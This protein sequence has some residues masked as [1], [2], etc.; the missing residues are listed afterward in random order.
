MLHATKINSHTSWGVYLAFLFSMLLKVI[1]KPQTNLVTNWYLYLINLSYICSFLFSPTITPLVQAFS[2]PHQVITVIPLT[3]LT[4]S[5]LPHPNL[6]TFDLFCFGG[7]TVKEKMKFILYWSRKWHGDMVQNK[8]K[9]NTAQS[10]KTLPIHRK[11]RINCKSTCIVPFQIGVF[12]I[13]TM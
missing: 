3:D 5:K 13:W 4:A 9:K 2:Y 7:M 8:K 10:N 6:F 11:A 12:L 1:I